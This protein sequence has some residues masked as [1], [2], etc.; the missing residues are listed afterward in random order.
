M[1]ISGAPRLAPHKKSGRTLK[2]WEPASLASFAIDR[3]EICE[4]SSSR[5]ELLPTNCYSESTTWTILKLEAAAGILLVGAA[6]LAIIAAN[7]A[8]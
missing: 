6:I 1:V 5:F 2:N 3:T 7:A 8:S 4:T